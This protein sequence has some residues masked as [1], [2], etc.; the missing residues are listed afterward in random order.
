M[1]KKIKHLEFIQSVISRMASN[2]FQLKA[3]SVTIASGILL[4]SLS[5]I[6]KN[7][8]LVA[9]LPLVM[10]WLLDSYYLWQERLYRGLYDKVRN[11]ED[12]E[13]DFLLNT[14]SIKKK[15]WEEYWKAF[16]SL[17]ELIFYLS[18]TILLVA[19]NFISKA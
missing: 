9:F 18:F 2:S 12:S 3:W 1:E 19:I 8:Y 14:T 7:Y 11:L 4:L 16:F 10:F 15:P 6:N 17:T 13:C 5:D